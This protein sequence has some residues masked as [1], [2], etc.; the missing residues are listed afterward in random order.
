MIAKH[1]GPRHTGTEMRRSDG[2]FVVRLAKLLSNME[3][4]SMLWCKKR[5][6]SN[7]TLGVFAYSTYLYTVSGAEVIRPRKIYDQF[8]CTRR[9]KIYHRMCHY[10]LELLNRSV[11][12][13]WFS[14]YWRDGVGGVTWVSKYF[15][16]FCSYS[17]EAL[18]HKSLTPLR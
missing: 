8:K 17:C 5:A 13:P 9:N 4:V 18:M 10:L 6:R 14:K 1:V 15:R 11:M 3:S 7:R 2:F 12:L 16:G